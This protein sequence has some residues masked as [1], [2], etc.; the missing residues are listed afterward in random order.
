MPWLAVVVVAC[1]GQLPERRCLPSAVVPAECWRLRLRPKKK[2]LKREREREKE[3]NTCMTLMIWAL[4]NWTAENMA[5]F[6]PR[7]DIMY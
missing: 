4:M 5:M 2:K 1:A 6:T 3:K 7:V